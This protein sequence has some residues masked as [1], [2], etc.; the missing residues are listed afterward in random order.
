MTKPTERRSTEQHPDA[1]DHIRFVL[2]DEDWQAFVEL[3]NRP[4]QDMSGLA[5][6]LARPSVLDEPDD[7]ANADAS[8]HGEPPGDEP[9][10]SD[11]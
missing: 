9:Q 8:A 10:A 3:L 2:A 7:V 11:G 5:E 6:F 4:E 1:A